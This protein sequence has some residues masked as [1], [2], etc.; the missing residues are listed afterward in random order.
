VFLGGRGIT[1][2]AHENSFA[3]GSMVHGPSRIVAPAWSRI[4]K[5]TLDVTVSALLLTLLAPLF[6][7]VGIAI[8]LES[9]G[10][11]FYRASRAGWRGRPLRVLKFRKMFEDAAGQPLTRHLD[12]RF[13]RIGHLLSRS[14]IDELPQ[15]WNVLLGQMSL[16][17]PRPEDLAFVALHETEYSQILVVR[18]GITGLG[19][20]AFSKESEI[21]DPEDG[22]GHYVDRILP[23]KVRLDILYTRTWTV[24]GDCRILTWTVLPVI[25]RVD[26]AVNR[27]SGTLTVRRRKG[28]GKA[29]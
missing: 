16:V 2:K 21:L 7:V 4:V 6:V 24:R 8:K 18:P 11:V 19:Q 15:L 27:G 10:P 1:E 17:G 12:S 3:V 29:G 22:V 13:T 25:L 26:V 9:R 5:R 23:Q 14:K 20:L 28:S